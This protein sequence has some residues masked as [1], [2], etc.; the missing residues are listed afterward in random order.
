[1][2][3]FFKI[4]VIISVPDYHLCEEHAGAQVTGM[5]YIVI[6][7]DCQLHE[8]SEKEMLLVEKE[9]ALFQRDVLKSINQL[10]QEEGQ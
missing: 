6:G 3:R 4:E 7:D 8:I 2:D 10:P 5:D 1:M 9:T